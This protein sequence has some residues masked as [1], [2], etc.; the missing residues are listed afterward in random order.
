MKQW[1]RLLRH[2]YRSDLE[3]S[4]NEFIRDHD[5][6]EIRV[7]TNSEDEDWCAQVRYT[8]P[9]APTYCKPEE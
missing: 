6:T 3:Q 2:A 9:E 7:W 8:Y 1:I 4:L 5:V